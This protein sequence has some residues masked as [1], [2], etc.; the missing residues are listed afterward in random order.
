MP[1]RGSL[2][3]PALR[4]GRPIVARLISAAVF[5][6]DGLVVDVE[7]D[8][9]R[10]KLPSFSVSGL[11]G[12]G[13]RE[14][15][16]RIRSAVWNSG[17]EFPT[18][19]VLV[20]LSPPNCEKE[21]T[22]FDLPNTHRL[23]VTTGVLDASTAQGWGAFGELSLDGCTRAVTGTT[24][25]VLSLRKAGLKRLLVP[26]SNLEEARAV[27]AV[28]AVGVRN[29]RHAVQVLKGE[30]KGLREPEPSPVE[31]TV[32]P[33]DFADVIGHR[34][35]KRALAIAVAG[36]HNV[37]L[38]GPPGSGKSLLARRMPGLMRD[39]THE[40]LLEITQ[41]QSAA[42]I[43]RVRGLVTE[44]PFRAPH[45]TIS[46]AG[47]VGG[48]R[49]PRP[50]EITAA[51][52]GVLFLDELPE[53]ARAALE[54]L[55]E[56]LEER[57]ITISRSQYTV[58]F[59]AA[60]TL[61]AA[62]NPCPCGYLGHPSRP[63]RCPTDRVRRYVEKVS[64]PL[65]DRIDLRLDVQAPDSAALLGIKPEPALK[66]AELRQFVERASR[67]RIDRGRL[68]PNRE[69]QWATRREWGLMSKRVEQTFVRHARELELSSR[70]MTRVLRIARTIAD[71]AASESIEERHLLEAI[72]YRSYDL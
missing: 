70:G 62:M 1:G 31:E 34:H 12:K 18:G 4:K 37:L 68:R 58:V 59:P 57:T 9:S 50:G 53:F 56:P 6:I 46:W 26:A 72:G 35:V 29:L 66:T 27:P 52:L 41:I 32:P 69:L 20:N 43:K 47:L 55:R 44:R 3:Q 13:I 60:F 28:D 49:V 51:H 40:E 10:S 23:L 36:G 7:V 16:E 65:L 19:R 22:V 67:F 54:A 21:A 2:R 64:G 45:H 5:G 38:V 30:S 14:S 42:G 61:V 17:Y 24:G 8:S 48:G 33:L 71:G 39:P 63:C 25:L 11:P 15:R